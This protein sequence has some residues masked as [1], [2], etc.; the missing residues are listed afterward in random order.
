MGSKER[1]GL[2]NLNEKRFHMAVWA[3]RQSNIKVSCESNLHCRQPYALNG[4]QVYNSNI[5]FAPERLC[6]KGK[7]RDTGFRGPFSTS[8]VTGTVG[9][10]QRWNNP[11]YLTSDDTSKINRN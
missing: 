10:A 9:A 8:I 11:N 4:S 7:F 6:T 5:K 2:S 1:R 3:L